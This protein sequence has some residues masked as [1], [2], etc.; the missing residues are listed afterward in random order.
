MLV[1]QLFYND[2]RAFA[3]VGCPVLLQANVVVE[4]TN[5]KKTV[6]A[7]VGT[8]LSQLCAKN[9]VKVCMHACAAAV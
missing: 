7:V 2:S 3:A 9:G 4:F 8:P 1:H 5:S 6:N